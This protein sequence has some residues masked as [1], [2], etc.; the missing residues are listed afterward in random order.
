[1]GRF[2]STVAFYDRYR[3]PYPPDFFAEV[4]GRLRFT[5]TERLLDI[6]CGPGM[7]AIGFAPYVAFCL[8]VD[9]EPGMLAAARELAKEAGV[10]LEL[11]ESRFEDLP[12]SAGPFQIAT[13]G[14]ALHWLDKDRAP[15]M[16][17]QMVTSGGYILVCGALSVKAPENPWAAA[18]RDLRRAWS[19]DADHPYNHTDADAWFANTPFRK[20]DE[21]AVTYQHRVTVASLIGRALSMST[22]SPTVLGERRASFEATLRAALEPFVEEGTLAEEVHAQAQVF[23]R[24]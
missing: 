18:L 17:A 6:A 21:I 10:R 22:T 1:M 12:V 11:I 7:L 19:D 23:R 14:R 8:G 24:E 13:V 4:A 20:L 16:I 15:A 9:P 5:G 2:E 3:E